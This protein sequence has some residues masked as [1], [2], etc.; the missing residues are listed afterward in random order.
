MDEQTARYSRGYLHHWLR[1]EKPPEQAARQVLAAA[2]RI[3]R[4]GRLGG[5]AIAGAVEGE[6]MQNEKLPLSQLPQ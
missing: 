6:R 3:W 4:A 1:G 5:V 2:D